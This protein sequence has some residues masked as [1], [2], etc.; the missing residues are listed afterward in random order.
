MTNDH[1]IIEIEPVEVEQ[2][3]LVAGW[4]EAGLVIGIN[5][6]LAHYVRETMTLEQRMFLIQLIKDRV[7]EIEAIIIGKAN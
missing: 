1:D 6:G 4:I 7:N 3:L 5:Q 2:R